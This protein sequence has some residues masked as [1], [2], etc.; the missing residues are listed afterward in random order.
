MK[1]TIAFLLTLI[2]LLSMAVAVI[3]ASAEEVTPNEDWGDDNG[4]GVYE[5]S[6]A[7]DLL[8]F[9]SF[10]SL[11]GYYAEKT[12]VL[13]NDIDMTGVEFFYV[14]ELHGTLDGQGHAIKNLSM[15]GCGFIRKLMNGA[16]VKNIRFINVSLASTA[17]MAGIIGLS[18]TGD[19]KFENIYVQGTV[20]A[21]NLTMIGGFVGFTNKGTE[22]A[23]NSVSF[24]NCVSDVV[25]TETG[26]Q[27]GGFLGRT[28]AF[29]K[30][31]F[32]DCAFLGDLSKAGANSSNFA[33]MTIGSV[34]MTRC[35]SLGRS[36]SNY[37]SGVFVFL[38][39]N[40]N[41]YDATVTLNDCYAAISGSTYSSGTGENK[42]EWTQHAVG[43][44]NAHS[45]RETLT[46][47]YGGKQAL[48]LE[49]AENNTVYKNMELVE[50]VM[51]YFA[52]GDTVNLTKDNF[53]ANYT[54][55]SADD[56][57]VVMGDETVTY[58]T[59]KTVAKVMPA[60][61]KALIETADAPADG[62]GDGNNGN[63]GGNAGG[64][65]GENA[66]GENA[67]PPAETTAD[68]KADT[69]ADTNNADGTDAETE[70]EKSG[71]GSVIGGSAIALAAVIG[72]AFALV[73][74]KKED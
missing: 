26:A 20:T 6:T 25:F 51:Q 65:N 29:S 10:A 21:K 47:N 30:A 63:D 39:H 49:T 54:A 68:T 62:T 14:A 2:M 69:A 67:N 33:G 19:V 58:A 57:W 35:V 5:I 59:D 32:T 17:D 36:S 46:V 66:G 8:A 24:K 3:P 34:E 41:G 38:H 53:K 45:W 15:T 37:Q 42:T 56:K 72:G 1:K 55:L 61:V 22:S 23:M 71:C 7:A 18:V 27:F 11:E 64:D 60:A 70:A 4:D 74:K 9:S 40:G 43:A 73:G 50:G 31:T 52:K 16:V 12:V 13:T 48:Q 28:S 44:H